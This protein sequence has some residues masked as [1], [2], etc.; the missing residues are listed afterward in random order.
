[1]R[2]SL[3]IIPVLLL[4]ATIGAPAAHADSMYTYMFTY[5]LSDGSTFSFTTQ[6][7]DPTVALGTLENT[8]TITAQT[9]SGFFSGTSL[10]FYDLDG[11]NSLV[12]LANLL[13]QV[14][15][16]P[17]IG[18]PEVYFSPSD[19]SAPGT[20]AGTCEYD[21]ESNATTDSLIVTAVP[22]PEP[23]TGV[24]TM[25]LGIGLALVVMRKRIPQGFRQAT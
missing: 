17:L 21:C 25:L 2:K 8:S 13:I 23:S 1:M 22:T 6:A 3:W 20:Y 9:F 11:S 18:P 24:L 15:G 19:Y 16:G 5:Q 4:F 10:L 12:P 7:L 14:S